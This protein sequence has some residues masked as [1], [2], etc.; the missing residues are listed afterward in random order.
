MGDL[1]GSLALAREFQAH[2]VE[3]AMLA[4]PDAEAVAFLEKHG[5]IHFHAGNFFQDCDTLKSWIPDSEYLSI[6]RPWVK[7]IVTVDD[8]G[9]AAV[10]ADLR[11]NVLYPIPGSLTH[12]SFIPLKSEFY[13]FNTQPRVWRSEVY[14]I[15]VT[16]GGADKFGFTPRVIKALEPLPEYILVKV[17]LGPAF[18]YDSELTEALKMVDRRSWA[19]ERCVDNIARHMAE[20][21]LAVCSG[22]LT[23]FEMACVGTP[24]VIVC[25]ETFEVATA[26]RLAEMGYG[27][28]LGF[29]TDWSEDDLF[30]SVMALISDA[31]KRIAM[32]QRGRE[33]VDG[34]GARR[35]VD[36]IY[37]VWKRLGLT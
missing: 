15:L 22:G 5:L 16:L 20:A 9:P 4:E 18:R 23:L 13:Y 30:N 19:V 14:T 17:I 10:L 31:E 7:L 6:L 29:G 2:G 32:G 8:D 11:I 35:S 26:V 28:N 25:G 37:Q 1:V 33:L 34:Q 3:V 27:I 21:D 12:P 36:T 24:S